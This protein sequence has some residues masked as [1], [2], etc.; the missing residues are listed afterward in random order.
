MCV[1]DNLPRE[2]VND[3]DFSALRRYYHHSGVIHLDWDIAVT[4]ESLRYFHNRCVAEMDTVRIAPYMLYRP[5]TGEDVPVLAHR[6]N[7]VPFGL[8]YL[9]PWSL[10]K[11]TEQTDDGRF[12]DTTFSTWLRGTHSFPMY[13]PVVEPIHVIHLH[14]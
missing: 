14:Y 2:P 4:P 1:D 12:N 5:S 9:P 7:I 6:R 10:Q 11:W 3:Y 8:V 13:L